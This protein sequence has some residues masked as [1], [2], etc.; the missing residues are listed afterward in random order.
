M[1]KRVVV[2][3]VLLGLAAGAWFVGLYYPVPEAQRAFQTFMGIAAVYIAAKIVVEEA[4]LKRIKE[5][6]TRYVF[7]KTV[8]IVALAL[9]GLVIVTVWVRDPSALFVAYGL[10]GAGV[11]IAL[12]DVFKNF[13]GGLTVFFSGTYQVGDR[14]EMAGT[15]GDVID[16]GIMY[17][18]V[19]E[20]EEWVKADQATGRIVS[21]PNGTV[22][23]GRVHNYTGNNS[24][25][26]D[27]ITVPVT[28]DSDWRAARD[29]FTGIVEEETV[30]VTERAA[31]EIR[32]IRRRYFLSERETGPQVFLEVTD[33]WVN[34]HVRFITAARKRRSTHNRI[35]ERFLEAVE[36][37]DDVTV[38]SQTIDIVGFPGKGDT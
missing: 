5:A 15:K 36:G 23:G 12:Q 26:W 25:I 31:E 22:L 37:H 2:V 13:V 11:A 10:L 24:F 3:L 28:Y 16:I 30:D 35:S 33:N 8:S 19:L 9:S 18:R 21:I 20:M 17:T 34:L 29:L 14:I 1:L 38:A 7:R 6:K 27:E 32:D 4:A